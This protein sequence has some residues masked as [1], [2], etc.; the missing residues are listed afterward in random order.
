MIVYDRT[1]RS[2]LF[3][4]ALFLGAAIVL[5]SWGGGWAPQW[6]AGSTAGLWLGIVAAVWM[7][8][9]ALLAR[10]RRAFLLLARWPVAPLLAA[11]FLAATVYGFVIR[12]PE[13]WFGGLVAS[14]VS[15][16]L[17]AGARRLHPVL[18]LPLGQRQWWLRLH[19][20]FGTLS[21]P[22]AIL[23]SGFQWGGGLETFL[24]IVLIIVFASGIFGLLL[25]HF[26]PRQI[27]LEIRFE[28]FPEQIP[29]RLAMRR[30]ESDALVAELVGGLGLPIH[31]DL[32]DFLQDYAV[33]KPGATADELDIPL[34]R[35]EEHVGKG[36]AKFFQNGAALKTVMQAALAIGKVDARKP[37]KKFPDFVRRTYGPEYVEPPNPPPTAVLPDNAIAVGLQ[38]PMAQQAVNNARAAMKGSI[39]TDR[40]INVPATPS[41][42]LDAASSEPS[43][44]KPLSKLE[45]ARRQSRS[46]APEVSAGGDPPA[47][48]SDKPPAK[49]GLSKIEQARLAANRRAKSLSETV[50]ADENPTASGPAPFTERPPASSGLSKI[51]QARLQAGRLS[52]SPPEVMPADEPSA[53]LE[54]PAETGKPLSK[55]ELARRQATKK[56]TRPEG[57]PQQT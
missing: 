35:L 25:Q 22:V 17:L 12:R 38:D 51:E 24:W 39:A 20:W 23:H 48:G 5:Y 57:D 49:P 14:G 44:A 28:T 52:E 47:A 13:W 50:P 26:I 55:L 45:L 31:E 36:S 4:S 15:L 1:Q 9:A 3:A 18:Y 53:A 10:P 8:L 46:A 54:A 56:P 30:V 21:A 2:W 29:H 37:W 42:P 40:R 33:L 7:V 43:E 19:I 11:A 16:F 34:T 41:I 6:R 32:Q 27:R